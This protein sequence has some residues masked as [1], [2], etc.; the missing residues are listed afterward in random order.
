MNDLV[1]RDPDGLR[2]WGSV[3]DTRLAPFEWLWLT[4]VLGVPGLV[5]ALVAALAAGPFVALGLLVVYVLVVSWWV[6]RQGRAVL[7]AQTDARPLQDAEA[8]RLV[9]LV[10][11]VAADLGM[12]PPRVWIAPGPSNALIC[13]SGAPVLLVRDELPDELTRTELEAVVTHCLVR[14]ASGDLRRASLAAAL[15][16]LAGPAGVSNFEAADTRA[17]S[18]TR[19]PP[20]LASAI[21][22][23]RAGGSGTRASFWFVPS[24][25]TRPSQAEREKRLE[26]L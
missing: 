26:D 15:G 11:G 23:A 6:G 4:V 20:A 13:R 16:A 7:A 24:D 8:P 2:E 12:E 5:M 10:R 9:S 19:Y 25:R 1:S 18:M 22:K 14:I 17:V 21:A 3:D